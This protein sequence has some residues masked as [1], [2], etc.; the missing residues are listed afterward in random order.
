MKGKKK[1]GVPDPP[2]PKT[3]GSKACSD[4][5]IQFKKRSKTDLENENF[6]VK[7]I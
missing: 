6:G 3:G 7:E 4:P 1:C 2:E 5:E